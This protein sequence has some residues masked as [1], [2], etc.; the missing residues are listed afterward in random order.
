MNII[1]R[2]HYTQT[3]KLSF[4]DFKG[5]SVLNIKTIIIFFQQLSTFI[6]QNLLTKCFKRRAYLAINLK[7]KYIVTWKLKFKLN[8][9]YPPA[10]RNIFSNTALYMFK[11]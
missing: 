4:I 10:P 6:L 7:I 1:P 2:T 5:Q 9:F 3:G 8:I 11:Y